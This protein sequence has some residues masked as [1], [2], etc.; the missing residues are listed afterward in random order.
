MRNSREID[1]QDW[2]EAET[3]E[4]ASPVLS[5]RRC[6]LGGAATGFVMMAS[7]LLLP[8][9]HQEADAREGANGGALGGRRGN[10]RRGRHR[11][12]GHQKRREKKTQEHEQPRG[13]KNG[14]NRNVAIH[15]NNYRTTPVQVQGWQF[16]GYG[17]SPGIGFPTPEKYA[18]PSGWTWSPIPARA[19]DGSHSTKSFV[20]TRSTDNSDPKMVVVQIG[21]DHL[22]WCLNEPFWW[23]RAEIRTGGWSK[24]GWAPKGTL[25]H[26]EFMLVRDAFSQDGIKV[27]RLDDTEEHIVFTVDL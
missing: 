9:S 6:L 16:D 17:T 12:R 2:D 10:N 4:P 5:S 21:T 27:T 25:L 15:V 22:V 8:A 3:D 18:T 11:Q 14:G 23:P 1:G 7:G 24:E 19:T 26:S 13:T 20:C